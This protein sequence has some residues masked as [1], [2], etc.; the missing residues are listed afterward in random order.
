MVPFQSYLSLPPG[1]RNI[2][3]L[4][5]LRVTVGTLIK[6]LHNC[7]YSSK[8]GI[9]FYCHNL[10]ILIE[11]IRLKR[12][13]IITVNVTRRSLRGKHSF[14]RTF[15]CSITDFACKASQASPEA[16]MSIT[17]LSLFCV[18]AADLRQ[19]NEV[20]N[21]IQCLNHWNKSN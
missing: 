15:I 5:P 18:T 7:G 13:K 16:S 1:D 6:P 19:S 17:A 9:P 20:F 8:Y 10:Y 12:M 2:P 14:V 11:G 3:R 4:P 21:S